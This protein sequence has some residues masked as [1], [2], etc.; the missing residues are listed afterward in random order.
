MTQFIPDLNFYGDPQQSF[1]FYTY[2]E[3]GSNRRENITDWALQGFREHYGEEDPHPNPLPEGEG[4]RERVIGKWDIFYYVYGLLHHPEYRE[5]YQ[6]NLKRELPRVPFAKDFWAF[7]KAGKRLAEIHVDYEK[8]KEYPLERIE[9]PDEPLNYRIDKMKL[10]KDKS[11]LH[12]NDF[13]TLEGIPKECF[14]YRLGNRSALEWV[15]DQ[16][17][18][19]TDKRSGITN[20]PNNLEDPEYILRL[21]GQVITVSL[22]TVDIVK[23][24]PDILF[25][26]NYNLID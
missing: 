5:R 9:N 1:P 22:E 26:K 11:E 10:S 8:Q 2:D 19:K 15:I 12:Y 14:D 21:L 20:D 24:L 25:G 17:Q 3:D 23:S 16:Y 13:L 18:I 6:A 7:S 4:A